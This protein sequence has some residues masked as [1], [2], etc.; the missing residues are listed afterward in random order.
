MRQHA[1]RRW[2]RDYVVSSRPDKIL[3]HLAI[4]RTSEAD[5]RGHIIRVALDQNDIRSLDR[6]IG[7]RADRDA[8]ICLREGGR[9]V[10]AV[11]GHG[12]DEAATLHLTH[13]EFF[14]VG[15]N[16]VDHLIQADFR[17]HPHCNLAFV[18]CEHDAADTHLFQTGDGGSRFWAD[19]VGQRNRAFKLATDEDEDH[20]LS[21]AAQTGNPRVGDGDILLVQIAGAYCHYG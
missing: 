9:I 7:S 6:D 1:G 2:N 16:F 11:A 17:G 15:Q 5:D 3:N 18:A 12:C 14:L 10:Y 19:D 20:R 8:D 13:F 21:L 4:G